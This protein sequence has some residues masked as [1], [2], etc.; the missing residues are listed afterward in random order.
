MSPQGKDS[1]RTDKWSKWS[2][3]V[4]ETMD[5][6]NR[7]PGISMMGNAIGFPLCVGLGMV[8]GAIVAYVQD[9][10]TAK[11]NSCYNQNRWN[12]TEHHGMS[13]IC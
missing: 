5:V 8:T 12:I 7:G 13:L 2:W 4:M 6:R 9:V 10:G 3:N 1:V 11:F